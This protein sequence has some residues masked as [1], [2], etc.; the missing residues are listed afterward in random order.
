[1]E[2]RLDV[3]GRRGAVRGDD[4]A[5][6]R[7]DVGAA[8]A[9]ALAEG[10]V[11]ELPGGRRRRWR[12]L[13][14]A[15][16]RAQP[17]EAEALLGK[18]LHP[19]GDLLLRQRREAKRHGHRHEA[20]QPRAR[21]VGGAQVGGGERSLGA[22]RPE[23]ADTPDAVAEAAEARARV[24]REPAA[25]RPGDVDERLEP[26]EPVRA[27]VREQARAGRRRADLQV[28]MLNAEC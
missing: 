15:A 25:D 5:V 14:D 23:R 9:Q 8:D 12:V 18:L 22:V 2:Q 3:G 16:A 21:A 6:A 4:V 13:E 17:R 24:H 1:M 28:G 19:R 7:G 11:G 10:A 20:L 26:R 27:A